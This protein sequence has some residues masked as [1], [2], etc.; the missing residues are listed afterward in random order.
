M[1]P[2]SPVIPEMDL[3]EVIFAKN[4]PQYIPLPAVVVDDG[5]RVI[6]RWQF[7]WRERLRILFG[8]SLWLSLL[9]FGNPLQPIHLDTV[10][11]KLEEEGTVGL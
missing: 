4:Q 3:T 9:T 2:V 8:G 11:P 6:T 5:T 7:S 1:K 10:S